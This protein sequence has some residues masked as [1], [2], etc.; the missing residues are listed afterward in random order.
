MLRT[1]FIVRIRSRNYKQRVAAI[2]LPFI[3]Q[4]YVNKKPLT[5]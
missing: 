3:A 5:I 2:P 1:G 4:Y